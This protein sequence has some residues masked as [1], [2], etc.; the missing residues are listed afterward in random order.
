MDVW[1]GEHVMLGAKLLLLV[2]FGQTTGGQADPAALAAQLGASRYAEREAAGQAL[3]QLGR[4]ALAALRTVRDSRDPEIRKRAYN[5]IQK[6][7][8]ALL[9]Q[10]SRVRLDFDN[11]PLTEVVKSLS[12]QTG[13]KIALIPENVTK[14]KYQRVTLRQAD[15]VPFWKAI[16]Q[17]CEVAQLQHNPTIY[18]AVSPREPTFPLTDSS[19]RPKMPNSDDGPFRVSLLSLHHERDVSYAG[20]LG[21]GG[22]SRL[23]VGKPAA[24]RRPQAVLPARPNPVTTEQFTAHLVVTAEPRLSLSQ[25]GT[26]HVIEAEDDLG[27]SLVPT[28]NGGPVYNRFAGYFGVVNGSIIQLQTPLH[29]P[30]FPGKKIKKLRGVIPLSVSSRLPDPLIV[31]LN[32]AAGKRFENLD[33][34][35]TVHEIRSIPTNRQT[36]LELSIKPKERGTTADP[37]EPGEPDAFNTVYR[38]DM[39]RLQLE[40]FDSQGRV[41]SWFPSSVDSETSRVTLTIPNLPASH[42]LKE[43][44]Y[45]TLTRATVNVPFEFKDM[46]MP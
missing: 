19:M 21:V 39:H 18:G 36:L 7:E 29:R 14:W 3:E 2:L 32:Q 40:I 13:F 17:L 25:N 34:E 22:G 45:H 6:I 30:E 12:Q 41:V 42:S 27:N 28:G 23:P 9:T 8:G 20:V 24:G 43:L 31:T 16:D 5:L 4:P 26:L 44:R 11:T 33:V 1:E 46:P 38:P 35:L 10:S 15:P 37:S